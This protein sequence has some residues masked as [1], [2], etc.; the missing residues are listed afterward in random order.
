MPSTFLLYGANGFVGEAAARQA[1]QSGLRPIL[2]GRDAAKIECLATST[3]PNPWWQL[4]CVLALTTW[5]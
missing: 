5:T 4:A 2:A 1:V 3:R